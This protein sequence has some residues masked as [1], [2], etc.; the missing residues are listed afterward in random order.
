[1]KSFCSI[2]LAVVMFM[3]MISHVASQAWEDPE[4]KEFFYG[5]A[6]S[7]KNG[8]TRSKEENF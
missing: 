2:L 5:W 6:S 3:A 1:M 7:E 8:C 4:Y